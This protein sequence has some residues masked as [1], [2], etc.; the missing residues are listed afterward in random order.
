MEFEVKRKV[1]KRLKK[2]LLLSWKSIGLSESLRECR[3][4]LAQ[5]KSNIIMSLVSKRLQMR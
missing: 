3:V 1:K 5:E 2:P 4:R